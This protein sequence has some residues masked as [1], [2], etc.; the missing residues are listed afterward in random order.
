MQDAKRE[1]FDEMNRILPANHRLR[2]TDRINPLHMDKIAGI[3]RESPWRFHPEEPCP[4]GGVVSVGQTFLDPPSC[5][6]G[7]PIATIGKP[8]Q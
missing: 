7:T 6:L 2:I 1:V 8:T 4:E 3:T 5:S